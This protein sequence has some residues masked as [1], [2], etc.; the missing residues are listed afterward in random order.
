MKLDPKFK[1]RDHKERSASHRF[2]PEWQVI[3]PAIRRDFRQSGGLIPRPR[4]KYKNRIRRD[5]G[6]ID[7]GE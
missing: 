6:M 1:R 4:G 5:R 3:D 2:E 7:W